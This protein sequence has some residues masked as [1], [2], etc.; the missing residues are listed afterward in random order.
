[1]SSEKKPSLSLQARKFIE[2]NIEDI[3]KG[4]FNKLFLDSFLVDTT[5]LFK[6]ICE[7]LLEVSDD[8]VS[9][10]HTS[11]LKNRSDEMNYF[12]FHPIGQGLFYTGSIANDFLNFV[13]DCGSYSGE[14]CKKRAIDDYV[15]SLR[16]FKK[17]EIDFFVLSHLHRDHFNGINYLMSKIKINKFYLPFIG[18]DKDFKALVLAGAVFLNGL[19]DNNQNEAYAMF[20]LMLSLYDEESIEGREVVLVGAN[21]ENEKEGYAYTKIT[22]NA[23][24]NDKDYWK[25]TLLNRRIDNRQLVDLINKMRVLMREHQIESITDLIHN[26]RISD[27][28]QIYHKVFGNDQN[29]TSTIL[30]H[31]P[32]QDCLEAYYNENGQNSYSSSIR[33][34]HMHYCKF[35][36]CSKHYALSPISL[37]TGDIK[38]DME[39]TNA[40]K[41][42][43]NNQDVGILQ[44]PHHGAYDNYNELDKRGI[45]AQVYIAPYG[46]GNSHKHPSPETI[47]DLCVKGRTFYSA[48]QYDFFD[49]IIE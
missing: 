6:E 49:Y 33:Y 12:K 38:A 24:F 17:S 16:N 21:P 26:H 23:K 22:F 1:M 42:A 37:L 32:E 43:L 5:S 20:N 28:A 48:N 34:R 27:I 41:N 39:L 47:E 15:R 8:F 45:C 40:I 36:R 18:D 35:C 10:L 30:L 3:E 13:Y 46:L 44:I 7:V 9:F 2:E 19:S 25:F 29:I 4:Y 14:K 31:E 11:I